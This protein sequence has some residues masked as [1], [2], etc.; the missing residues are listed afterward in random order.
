MEI[1]SNKFHTTVSNFQ[2][3]LQDVFASCTSGSILYYT[4]CKE[5]D[6]HA[7]IPFLKSLPNAASETLGQIISDEEILVPKENHNIKEYCSHFLCISLKACFVINNLYDTELCFNKIQTEPCFNK[8]SFSLY[9]VESMF[10]N[11]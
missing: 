3:G 2:C 5:N 8:M 9:L 10:C 6:A 7:F 1:P 11:K 4:Y